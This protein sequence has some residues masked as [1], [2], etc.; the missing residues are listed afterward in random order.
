MHSFNT[1]HS[2]LRNIDITVD[3]AQM[4]ILNRKSWH[5][6]SIRSSWNNLPH[7]VQVINLESVVAERLSQVVARNPYSDPHWVARGG[8]NDAPF[9]GLWVLVWELVACMNNSH[10]HNTHFWWRLVQ[11]GPVQHYKEYNLCN[12]QSKVSLAGTM[13]FLYQMQLKRRSLSVRRIFHR[14]GKFC[15]ILSFSFSA[16]ENFPTCTCGL[17]ILHH[18]LLHH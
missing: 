18:V 14:D 9:V 4:Y 13:I 11:T 10:R 3:A 12:T 7:Q 2:R 15:R 1:Y 17:G 6:P 16:S 8:N 5:I